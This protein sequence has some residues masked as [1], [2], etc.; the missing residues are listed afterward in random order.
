MFNDAA[1]LTII[2]F[3]LAA[4]ITHQ[5][6]FGH[7]FVAFGAMIVGEVLYGFLLGH[8]LGKIR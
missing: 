1:A 6:L 2:R 8:L 3:A 4:A 5:F 7:A